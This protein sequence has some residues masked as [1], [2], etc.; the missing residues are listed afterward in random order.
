MN[1]RELFKELNFNLI[2]TGN[3]LLIYKYKTDY[4]EINV[5][6]YIDKKA[7]ETQYMRFK[8]NTEND[9]VPM[10]ERPENIKHSAFYGHWQ[11]EDCQIWCELHNAIHQQLVELGWIQ[12]GQK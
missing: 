6:F 4:D 1:A 5:Y 10:K 2:P 12:G 3:D 8:D 11:K 7:Y 9:F